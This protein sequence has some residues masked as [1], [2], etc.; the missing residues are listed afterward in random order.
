MKARFRYV[1]TAMLSCQYSSASGCCLV[2]S[3]RGRCCIDAVLSTH[4]YIE[5]RSRGPRETASYVMIPLLPNQYKVTSQLPMHIPD[6][7]PLSISFHCIHSSS[8]RARD[9]YIHHFS[10]SLFWVALKRAFLGKFKMNLGTFTT[11]TPCK[12]D[13]LG[14]DGHTFGMDSAQVG[15]FEKSNQVSFAGF[16]KGHHGTA[17]ETQIRLEILCDLTDKTLE[18]QLSDQ[19]LGRLLVTSDFSKSNGT[20]SV[21]VRLLDASGCRGRLA[22]SLGGKLLARCLA[23]S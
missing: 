17:L 3:P 8:S 22:S 2:L 14:H 11:D 13:V 9:I 15:V 16:L 4:T 10:F 5:A 1:R 18:G 21:S 12:L 19:K 7:V 20:R 23:P 6:R